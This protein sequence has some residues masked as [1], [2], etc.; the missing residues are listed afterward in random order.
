[1]EE[2]DGPWDEQVLWLGQR[3]YH[4]RT[5]DHLQGSKKM[6]SPHNSQY[7]HTF[8]ISPPRSRKNRKKNA[9]DNDGPISPNAVLLSLVCPA[10][11]NLNSTCGSKETLQRRL[12]F[13]LRCDLL[14]LPCEKF[15]IPDEVEGL[16]EERVS[17]IDG[18]GEDMCGRQRWW[19][20]RLVLAWAATYSG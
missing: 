5:L 11:G 6:S 4:H 3:M 10:V 7:L 18:D 16:V 2:N 9:R 8:L 15:F 13:V 12:A 19:R 20:W 14:D 1:M 17:D